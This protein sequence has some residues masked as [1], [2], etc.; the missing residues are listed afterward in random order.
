MAQERCHEAGSPSLATSVNPERGQV[1]PAL[2]VSATAVVTCFGS[3]R[4]SL[5]VR[6]EVKPFAI[7]GRLAPKLNLLPED[8]LSRDALETVSEGLSATR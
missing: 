5:I 8:V 3:V 1:F 7:G 4:T 2:P 6:G